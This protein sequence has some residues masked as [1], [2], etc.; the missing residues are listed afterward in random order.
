MTAPSQTDSA[1]QTLVKKAIDA[2]QH[3]Y[4]PYSHYPVGAALQAADG[5]IYTGCNIE[6]A[7][8]PVTI[9]GE[10]TALAKAVSEGQRQFTVIVVATR[11]AGS[12]CGMCRQMLFEFSPTMRVILTDLDG[13]IRSDCSL[14]DLLPDGF[15]P[16]SLE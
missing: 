16:S 14:S 7:A 9:C 4:I 1:I 12:P 8:Y 15:G 11:N 6:N 3:A 13:N 5:T 10:R 2:T